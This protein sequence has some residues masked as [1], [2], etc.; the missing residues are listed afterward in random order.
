MRYWKKKNLIND[1]DTKVTE[2]YQ[3][4]EHVDATNN[5]PLI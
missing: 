1:F 3:F 4:I 2:K 5:I